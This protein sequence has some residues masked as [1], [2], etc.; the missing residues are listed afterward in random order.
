MTKSACKHW[1]LTI[2]NPTEEDGK[3][4][5]DKGTLATHLDYLMLGS[6]VGET[7]GLPHLHA[8]IVLKKRQR[9]T[10]LKKLYPRADIEVKRGTFEQ[11]QTYLAKDGH[12]DEWGNVHKMQDND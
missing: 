5:H 4:F 7:S 6:H 10:A 1:F 9:M 3:N 2:N 8:V 11:C 12:W